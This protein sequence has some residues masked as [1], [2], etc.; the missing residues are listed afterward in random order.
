[1]LTGIYRSIGNNTKITLDS[2][3]DTGIVFYGGLIGFLIAY[4]LCLQSRHFHLDGQAINIL[5]VC[6]PLFHTFARIGCFTSGCCYGRLYTGI[7]SV[8]YTTYIENSININLR[9]PVQLLESLFDLGLFVYLLTLLRSKEWR[10]KNIL[11]RYLTI[12]SIGRFFLEYL[13]GDIRR[14]IVDGLSFSQT[15]SIFLWL[16]LLGYAL[17]QRKRKL[18]INK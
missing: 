17:L 10:S 8:K 15:V 6:I 1:M 16:M 4:F 11:I 14:G 13:R 7:L 3:L 18:S 9:F 12:Y 2:I 5:A